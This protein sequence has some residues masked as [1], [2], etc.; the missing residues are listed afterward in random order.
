[1]LKDGDSMA[2]IGEWIDKGREYDK[3][4]QDKVGLRLDAGTVLK[5][6]DRLNE[7]SPFKDII[8]EGRR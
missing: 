6:E 1:M 8:I 5:P 3:L 4:L 2:L 7:K